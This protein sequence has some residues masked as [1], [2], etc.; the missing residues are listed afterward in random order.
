MRVGGYD[1]GR[2]AW[3]VAVDDGGTTLTGW[4]PEA[5]V[6]ADP[7]RPPHEDVYRWLDRHVARIEQA[8]KDRAA[9]RD[10]P[11]PYDRL[12]L[13]EDERCPPRS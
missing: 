7:G 11:A 5:L 9:G 3:R 13:G 6:R 10:V 2:E 1:R 8:L 12:S 4:V